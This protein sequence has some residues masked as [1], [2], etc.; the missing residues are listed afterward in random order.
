MDDAGMRQTVDQIV[1]DFRGLIEQMAQ[2]AQ[3]VADAADVAALEQ[4]MRRQGLA[5]LQRA[6]Q[7]LLQARLDQQ[8]AQQR[9]CPRCG[10]RRRHKGRRARQ[11]V[12]LLGPIRVEAVY[13]QC[14]CEAGS[15][16]PASELLPG[17]VTE[18]LAELI[19]LLGITQSSFAHAEAALKKLLGLDLDAQTLRRLTEARGETIKPEPL[20]RPVAGKLTGSCDGTMVHTR[21]TG[22]RELKAYR[23]DDEAGLRSSGAAVEPAESFA[24]RLRHAALAQKPREAEDFVFVS[25]TAEWIKQAVAEHLPEVSQHV[26][27]F[28][29]A[30]EHI[31]EA[32]RAIYGEGTEQARQWGRRWSQTLLT[33]GGEVT[34]QRLR[35][36]R[37][38]SDPAQQALNQLLGYLGRHRE[39][40]DYP[41]YRREGL[42][43]SSGPM[44]STCKQLGTRL[45]GPGM[46][47]REPNLEPMAKLLSLWQ[48]QQWNQ[49]WTIAA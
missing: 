45:K 33:E 4:T 5:Q 29:H 22:W 40:M 8:A 47:W 2:Q 35:R 38:R 12:G 7:G 19:C 41:R 27:D 13:W 18:P 46:R 44:E 21:E 1:A 49:H 24:S 10:A 3:T 23:F 9:L 17:T 14:P 11:S 25:D 36:A 30:S 28:Y 15:A 48:T 32:A 6:E 31:H 20:E 37:F 39:R 43:I 42:A 34:Y 26:V 16:Q